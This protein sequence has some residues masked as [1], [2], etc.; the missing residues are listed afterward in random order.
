[1][2]FCIASNRAFAELTGWSVAI[3]ASTQ[4]EH[5][6]WDGFRFYDTIFPLFLFIAGVAMPF[7]LGKRIER[8][9]DK[10]KLM[11]HVVHRGL[12]LIVLGIIYNNGLFQMINKKA[13]TPYPRICV[14]RALSVCSQEI[15]LHRCI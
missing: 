10:R 3:W 9:D 7:S 11:I 4:L 8:G 13:S 12:I 2:A 14:L 15:C 5:V 6:A 1:M